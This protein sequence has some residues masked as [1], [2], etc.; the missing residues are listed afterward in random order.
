MSNELRV[1]IND[2]LDQLQTMMAEQKHLD[3][4]GVGVVEHIATISKFWSV[5]SEEDKD[6]I[7]GCQ[8]AID[9]QVEW[10]GS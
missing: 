3:D 10:T 7:Q 6:Y 1:K 8:Y 9:E 5:L 4:K 2:R